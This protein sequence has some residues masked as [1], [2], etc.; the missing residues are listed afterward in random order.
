MIDQW[1]G[2]KFESKNRN[3]ILS[4]IRMLHEF[5]SMAQFVMMF[6]LVVSAWVAIEE[7]VFANFFKKWYGPDSPCQ[8]L[9]FILMS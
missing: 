3:D 7:E 4:H 8:G 1:K 6:Q 2:T 9:W 5:T